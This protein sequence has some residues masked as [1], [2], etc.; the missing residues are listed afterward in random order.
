MGCID[1]CPC[2]EYD[3]RYSYNIGKVNTFGQDLRERFRS[4]MCLLS[5]K[6]LITV[7]WA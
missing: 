6:H 4:P 3:Y 1:G 5:P 2:K 7:F